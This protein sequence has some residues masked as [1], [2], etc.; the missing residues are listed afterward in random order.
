MHCFQDNKETLKCQRQSTSFISITC[1]GRKIR[2]RK[3]TLRK[4]QRNGAAFCKTQAKYM[5]LT[6][7]TVYKSVACVPLLSYPVTLNNF[8]VISILIV[9]KLTLSYLLNQQAYQEVLEQH[10]FL[11]LQIIKTHIMQEYIESLNQIKRSP[12]LP[13][14]YVNL[15]N[16]FE[17]HNLLYDAYLTLTTVISLVSSFSLREK[18]NSTLHSLTQK[19][20]SDKTIEKGRASVFGWGKNDDGCCAGDKKYLFSPTPVEILRGIPILDLSC[21]MSHSLAITAD[22]RAFVWGANNYGQCGLD[23]SVHAVAK[24]TLVDGLLLTTLKAA[25]C[26]G[27]HNI[28]ISQNGEAYSWGLNSLGQCGVSSL[29]K[30]AR[31]GKVDL[32]WSVKAVAC[33]LGHTVYLEE[34]GAVYASGW[35]INGQLGLGEAYKTQ[36]TVRFPKKVLVENTI[37]VACGGNHTIFISATGKAYSTGLNSSGQLGLTHLEDCTQPKLID[38]LAKVQATY[39]AC[40]EEFSFVITYEKEVYAMGL[41]N[42]GQL[43]IDPNDFPFTP[44][45]LLVTA[46]LGK[47]AENISCGKAGAIAITSQGGAYG[48]GLKPLADYEVISEVKQLAELKGINIGEIKSGREF[49][50]ILQNMPDPGQSIAYSESFHKSIEPRIEQAIHIQCVDTNGNYCTSGGDR[51][52]CIATNMNDEKEVPFYKLAIKDKCDGSYEVKYEFASI[53]NYMVYIICNGCLL[54]MS[55]YLINVAVKARSV[56]DIDRSGVLLIVEENYIGKVFQYDSGEEIEMVLDIRDANGNECEDINI[57]AEDVKVFV[58]AKECK[59]MVKYGQIIKF[60]VKDKGK[61]KVE[62]KVF[63]K[64]ISIYTE[65]NVSKSTQKQKYADIEIV[66]GP[67]DPKKCKIVQGSFKLPGY[68]ELTT[69]RSGEIH[70]YIIRCFDSDGLP[71]TRYNNDFLAACEKVSGGSENS[72]ITCHVA[73]PTRKPEARITFKAGVCGIYKIKTT[74]EGTLIENGEILIKVTNGRPDYVFSRVYGDIC[75][76]GC[77]KTGEKLAKTVFVEAVDSYGNRCDTLNLENDIGIYLVTPAKKIRIATEKHEHNVYKGEYKIET[78][79]TYKLEV[80]IGGEKAIG[81]PYEIKIERNPIELEKEKKAK[82]D[83]MRKVEEMQKQEREARAKEIEKKQ[84]LEEEKRKEEAEKREE[85]EKKELLANKI[86]KLETFRKDSQRKREIQ[87]QKLKEKL[88]KKRKKFKRCGGGFV[89]PFLEHQESQKEITL[90]LQNF[91]TNTKKQRFTYQP[92]N[93]FKH[94]LIKEQQRTNVKTHCPHSCLVH[95]YHLMH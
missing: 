87:E 42:V 71:T 8:L 90:K 81:S 86:K 25:A 10:V 72:K 45:P 59:N 9:D 12:H 33:G 54:G 5:T 75:F 79:G 85:F 3:T 93:S 88:E 15:C 40:G 57:K 17:K 23:L 70:D 49:Y 38:S 68:K 91:F 16:F 69:V 27:A 44:V 77:L 64:L 11:S 22:G 80:F 14:P 1:I 52:S 47:Q 82:E 62:V 19:L 29:D 34:N 95:T 26:G 78:A 20:Q 55:P 67:A 83:A 7:R 13:D 37:H 63:S 43:G 56:A 60:H 65:Y 31:I 92:H 41:N 32:E 24:P 30:I 89:V 58:D 6:R 35:N 21:G 48:W 39:A 46:L 73:Q 66:P 28:V 36:Q 84:L 76:R 74:L 51:I 50:L 4:K 2:R 94:K 18:V 61:H 53:G